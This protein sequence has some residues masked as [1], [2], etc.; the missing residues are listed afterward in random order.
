MSTSYRTL[1]K[2]CTLGILAILFRSG[3][4]IQPAFADSVVLK[5]SYHTS[6]SNTGKQKFADYNDENASVTVTYTVKTKIDPVTKMKEFDPAN[7]TVSFTYKFAG[8][9]F[10]TVNVMMCSIEGNPNTGKVTAFTFCGLAWDPKRPPAGQPGAGAVQSNGISGEINVAGKTGAITSSYGSDSGSTAQYT[11][12]TQDKKP[13]PPKPNPKTGQP[14]EANS[15]V[16]GADGIGYDAATG[17]LS[18]SGDTITGTP[19]PADPLRGASLN[20]SNYKFEGFTSD[21]SL[22]IFW[23]EGGEGPMTIANGSNTYEQGDLP[24]LYYDVADNLF[25]GSPLDYTLAGVP[26]SSPFY[27]PNLAAISSPYLNSL[28]D[29]L[30]PASPDF[31]PNAYLYETIDPTTNLDTATDGFTASGGS[32]ATDAQFVADAPEPSTGALV[33]VGLAPLLLFRRHRRG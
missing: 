10:T 21:G 9:P 19:D 27:D 29:T 6:K 28:E 15:S 32:S 2:L 11:F 16:P 17:T 7:S 20:F 12:D 3:V 22:A 33:I 8:T 26:S 24:V 25:Y 5:G 30:D 23:S 1:V 13:A 18:I 14:E 31:D 4:A